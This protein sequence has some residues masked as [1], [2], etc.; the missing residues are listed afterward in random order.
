MGKVYPQES[1]SSSCLNSKRE[2]YT[3]WMKSLVFHSNGCT[4]Y[5]SNGNIVYRVDNYD[6]KGIREV[7]LMDLRG[8]VLCAIK[9]KSL[10]FGSWDGYRSNCSNSGSMEEPWFQVKRCNKM[11]RRKVECEI[12]IECQKY[13]IL[14]SSAKTAFMIVNIDGHIVAEAKQ[15]Y[16]PSGVALDNDVL[17]LDV[18][19]DTDHA[20]VMALVTV[21]ALICGRM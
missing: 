15:K 3:L 20:L 8:R 4:V 18:A 19:E 10:S 9:K 7:N 12:E 2:T 1:S 6:T 13:F 5:D 14:R 21:Y 11:M 17:T 16:S